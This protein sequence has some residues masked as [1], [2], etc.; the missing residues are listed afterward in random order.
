[1]L[2]PQRKKIKTFQNKWER[3]RGKEVIK[4]KNLLAVIRYS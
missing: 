4:H 2:K 1:M 3:K